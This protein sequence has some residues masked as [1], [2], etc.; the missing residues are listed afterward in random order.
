MLAGSDIGPIPS[1]TG[2]TGQFYPIFITL[3]IIQ[4][5]LSIVFIIYHQIRNKLNLFK[6]KKSIIKIQNNFYKRFGQMKHNCSLTI[7]LLTI[8]KNR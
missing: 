3:I 5:T 7:N 6:Q 8:I 4:M 1:S 2:R